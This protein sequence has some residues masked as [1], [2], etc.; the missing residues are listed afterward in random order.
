MV[1]SSTPS[2][3]AVLSPLSSFD[4]SFLPFSLGNPYSA[5]LFLFSSDFRAAV[6]AMFTTPQQGCYYSSPAVFDEI[7]ATTNRAQTALLQ[8]LIIVEELV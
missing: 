1:T 3:L 8:F 6:E 2:V 4:I 7:A 5:M